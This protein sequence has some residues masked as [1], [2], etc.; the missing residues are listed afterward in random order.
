MAKGQ[1]KSTDLVVKGSPLQ[2][3]VN[4]M[5]SINEVSFSNLQIDKSL[6][7]SQQRKQALIQLGMKKPRKQ[8]ETPAERKAAAKAR[9]K[10]RRDKRNAE[11][12][13][14]GLGP[15]PRQKLSHDEKVEKRKEKRHTK[16]DFFKEMLKTHPEEAKK[17][18]ID[19]NKWKF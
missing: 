4:S 11:L 16:N 12:T 17:F 7:L 6:P 5:P 19:P 18:G 13:K 14:L 9:A 15:Q 10:E 2:N 8:Y 1:G 3:A